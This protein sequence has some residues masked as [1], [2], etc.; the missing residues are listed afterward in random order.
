MP[1]PDDTL[2]DELDPVAPQCRPTVDAIQSALDG[3]AE[4]L[5]ADAHPLTCATCRERVRAAL[6]LLR[7]WRP[8]RRRS[9]CPPG[10]A[11][12]VL[13]AAW[14]RTPGSGPPPA[15]GAALRPGWPAGPPRSCSRCSWSPRGGARAGAEP[16]NDTFTG[17]HPAPAARPEPAPAPREKAPPVRIGDEVAR[18][19]SRCAARRSRSPTSV[20]VAPVLL[21][22][23]AG[24]FRPP[25]GPLP[26]GE[27]LE[28]A[29]K[30]LAELPDAARTGLEPVTGTAQ[31]ALDRLLRDVAAVKPRS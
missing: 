15:A 22:A 21:D 29:R 10:F 9:K 5:A 23:F 30:S 19:G 12:R 8:R 13:V 3:E 6:V 25:A 2:A 18:P 31:K 16:P 17:V 26:M 24:A 27:A 11:D 28:P 20:A 4:A 1:T 7:C 14:H